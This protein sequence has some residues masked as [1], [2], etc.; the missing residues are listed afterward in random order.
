[1]NLSTNLPTQPRF[2]MAIGTTPNLVARLAIWHRNRRTR[3]R[4]ATLDHHQLA[5][6]GLSPAQRDTECTKWF[7]QP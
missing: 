2:T 1:M 5:D 6:I 4:L 3:A 7:W